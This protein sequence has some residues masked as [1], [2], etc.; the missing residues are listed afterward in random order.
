MV[1]DHLLHLAY[2]VW[3]YPPNTTHHI[4]TLNFL[5]FFHSKQS[6]IAIVLPS[7]LISAFISNCLA[8]IADRYTQVIAQ[9]LIKPWSF[10]LSFIIFAWCLRSCSH[11]M[12]LVRYEACAESL[13]IWH[14]PIVKPRPQ[15]C[16]ALYKSL[17][18]FLALFCELLAW[19]WAM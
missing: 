10:W 15:F 7:L 16:V 14:L 6:V 12:W 8:C 13:S 11:D 2:R 1:A 19:S 4:N 5:F 18:I 17:C 9:T 3:N